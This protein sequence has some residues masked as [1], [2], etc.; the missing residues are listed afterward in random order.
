MFLIVQVNIAHFNYKYADIGHLFVIWSQSELKSINNLPYNDKYRQID[1]NVPQ[2]DNFQK[3]SWGGH[4]IPLQSSEFYLGTIGPLVWIS[5]LGHHS[6]Y[7]QNI[8]YNFLA[9]S[10]K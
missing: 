2:F 10:L 8:F 9:Q 3:C 1:Q 6:I 5:L 4:S 7:N